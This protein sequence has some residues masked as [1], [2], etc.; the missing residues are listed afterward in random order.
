ME[1]IS[2]SN[3]WRELLGGLFFLSLFTAGFIYELIDTGEITWMPI[4]LFTVFLWITLLRLRIWRV[5]KTKDSIVFQHVLTR[6]KRELLKNDQ[7]VV[8]ADAYLAESQSSIMYYSLIL[9]FN[10]EEVRLRDESYKNFDT[11]SDEIFEMFPHLR[12]DYEQQRRNKARDERR[13]DD[14]YT[15][16][17]VG[18][19]LMILILQ[20]YFNF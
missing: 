8:E 18:I 16:I 14:R 17:V 19:V 4:M 3:E 15:W 11:I 5:Y 6:K 7:V 20:K 10:G 2:K 13:W 9:K 12:Y 1:K